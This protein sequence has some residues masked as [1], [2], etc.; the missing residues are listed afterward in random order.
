MSMIK[1]KKE[2]QFRVKVKEGI[3][4]PFTKGKLFYARWYGGDGVAIQLRNKNLTWTLPIHPSFF[5]IIK[6]N[7][8]C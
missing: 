8:E 1:I 3:D 4:A 6:E 5:D 7:V 2:G